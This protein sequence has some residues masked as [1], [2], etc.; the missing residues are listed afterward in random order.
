[1][2]SVCPNCAMASTDELCS[3]K[4]Q[5]LHR[6]KKLAKPRQDLWRR[7]SMMEALNSRFKYVVAF[8][9]AAVIIAAL[10]RHAIHVYGGLSREEIRAGALIAIPA[11]A[12]LLIFLVVKKR[13]E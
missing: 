8:L 10:L 13:R 11:V 4:P 5:S 7:S 3:A 2:V 6:A 9:I 1:M 12:L